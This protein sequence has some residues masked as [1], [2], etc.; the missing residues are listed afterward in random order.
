MT[1]PRVIPF[2]DQKAVVDDFA[3]EEYGGDDPDRYKKKGNQM[4]LLGSV[5]GNNTGTSSPP[6][7]MPSAQPSGVVSSPTSQLTM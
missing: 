5:M 1:D 3:I 7:K 4:D 2:T 6:V